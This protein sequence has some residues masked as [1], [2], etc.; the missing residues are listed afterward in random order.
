[1]AF[2][3]TLEALRRGFFLK[4]PCCG[5]G[6]M[7]RKY[8]SPLVS[9]KNCGEPFERLRADDGP[10]WLTILVAGHLMVPVIFWVVESGIESTEVMLAILLPIVVVLCAIILPRAKG[11]FMA[12]IWVTRVRTKEIPDV[13]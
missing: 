11:V 7:L 13:F 5:K 9:C 1:M 12:L 2:V 10:A 3:T 4:C 8:L 6:A